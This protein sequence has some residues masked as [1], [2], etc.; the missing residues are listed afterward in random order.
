[1]ADKSKY[2][3]LLVQ[4]RFESLLCDDP[5]ISLFWYVIVYEQNVPEMWRMLEEK[6]G[7][8]KIKCIL[9]TVAQERPSSLLHQL[10]IFAA[11]LEY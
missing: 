2:W 8:E 1:M 7:T 4:N 3:S 9:N 10:D 6:L 11:D 5:L